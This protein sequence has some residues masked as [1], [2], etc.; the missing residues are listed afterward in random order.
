[1]SAQEEHVRISDFSDRE[2]LAVMEDLN[3]NG[4]VRS[5][6]IA[7]RLSAIP[8]LDARTEEIAHASHCV[9]IRMSWMRRYG[10]VEKGETHG[11]WMISEAGRRLRA[12]RVRGLV[13]T[14]ISQAEDAAGMEIAN[15]VGEKL[16]AAG[17]VEGRAMQRELEFQIKRR[18]RQPWYR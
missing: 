1:M 11:E 6:D 2:L 5:R 7:L 10:L 12:A 4:V 15:V 3:G 14:G 13:R 9:S 18:K 17:T 16:V 8:D